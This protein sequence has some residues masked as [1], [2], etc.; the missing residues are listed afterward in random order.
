MRRVQF[1][2]LLS[3]FSLAYMEWGGGNHCFVFELQA[4]VFSEPGQFVSNFTHPLI[5]AGFLGQ[6]IL[7]IATFNPLIR[8]GWIV[9]AIIL[10][11][12]PILLI[13]LS[14]ILSSNAK[15]IFS[16]LPFMGLAM[17]VIVK[18]E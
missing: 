15:I 7:L 1:L 13:F 9:V 18:L 16:C 6:L 10:L 4:K 12:V 14:G 2:L 8:F 5:L 3:S 11:G 17:W